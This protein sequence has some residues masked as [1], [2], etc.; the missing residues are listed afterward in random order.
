[1]D[2]SS[3]STAATGITGTGPYVING[4]TPGTPYYIRM[5][6][7]GSGGTSP[8]GYP[9]KKLYSVSTPSRDASDLIVYDSN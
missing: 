8:Y 2:G 4:L 7:T 6:A 3:W 1:M 5:T 9:W